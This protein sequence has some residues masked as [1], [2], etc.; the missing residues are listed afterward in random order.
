MDN[1]I[2]KGKSMERSDISINGEEARVVNYMNKIF[3][4]HEVFVIQQREINEKS[5]VQNLP[6]KDLE[7]YRVYHVPYF[8]NIS[9]LFLET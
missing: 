1:N 9:S 7:F 3:W 5:K 6:E 8:L 2:D 4:A